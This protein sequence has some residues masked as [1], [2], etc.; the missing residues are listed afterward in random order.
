MRTRYILMFFFFAFQIAQGSPLADEQKFMEKRQAILAKSEALLKKTRW[1]FYLSQ[2]AGSAYQSMKGIL[3]YDPETDTPSKEIQEMIRQD[4]LENPDKYI[5]KSF[6]QKVDQQ[7]NNII[8]GIDQ[9]ISSQPELIAQSNEVSFL[10]SFS[11]VGLGGTNENHWGGAY[12]FGLSIGFNSQT[13]KVAIKFFKDKE[14]FKNTVM[15]AVAVGGLVVKAGLK[16]AA[17][18]NGVK[19]TSG[20]AFYPPFVPGFQS[21]TKESFSFGFS[22]GITWPPSP[23]ADV[24]TYTNDLEQ[25]T[26]ARL[27]FSP[28]IGKAVSTE[29][30]QNQQLVFSPISH[31][32]ET[33][34]CSQL[35]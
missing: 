18:K 14:H 21:N 32:A 35:F 25:E 16:I 24:L 12:G 15:K 4:K 9:K 28:F 13:K 22:S 6:S 27:D 30:T 10:L 1:L 7:I 17:D 29:I 8:L 20:E 23:F 26:L 3:L 19:T 34:F 11:L 5:S 2:G 33:G 31:S